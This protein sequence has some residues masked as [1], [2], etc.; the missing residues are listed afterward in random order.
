M[1]SKNLA[2]KTWNILNKNL[3]LVKYGLYMKKLPIYETE[4]N[5]AVKNHLKWQIRDLK[6]NCSWQIGKTSWKS[7]V[8]SS[9]LRELFKVQ[10]WR[11]LVVPKNSYR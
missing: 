4:Q 5:N 8:R 11:F 3:S 9:I 6:K 2:D 1:L 7:L 10:F